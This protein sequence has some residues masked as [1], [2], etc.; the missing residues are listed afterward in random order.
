[1]L[2]SEVIYRV[3]QNTQNLNSFVYSNFEP[4]EI[5]LQ[6]DREVDKFL[7]AHLKPEQAGNLKGVDEIELDID[8]LRYLKVIGTFIPM[9][10]NVGNLPSN[11]R[12]LLNDRS[13][14]T[15]CGQTFDVSNRLFGDEKLYEALENPF[16]KPKIDSPISRIV[17]N[18]IRIHSVPGQVIGSCHIDYIKIPAKLYDI[19]DPNY[20]YLEFP[21]HCINWI[22]DLTRNRIAELTQSERLPSQIQ[23]STNF[24]LM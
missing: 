13:Q 6:F 4:K 19:D 15:Q 11:F 21:E 14:I 22:I 20:D 7:D 18:Q 16:L 2:A 1:M 12:N 10:T 5:W 8:N 3:N 23:E 17:G 9:S 24:N